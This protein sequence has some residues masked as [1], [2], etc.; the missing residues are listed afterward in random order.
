MA[1]YQV[2]EYRSEKCIAR[3]HKP[4]LTDKEEKAV[5]EHIKAALVRFGR[6][7]S[8]KCTSI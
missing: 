2:T 4:I 8:K 6:E 1:E 5:E 7:R 3:I